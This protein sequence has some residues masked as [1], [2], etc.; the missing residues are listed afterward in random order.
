MPTG[1][2]STMELLHSVQNAAVLTGVQPT[3]LWPCRTEFSSAALASSHLQNPIQVLLPDPLRS[4]STTS[5]SM[6]LP[7]HLTTIR[8]M[9]T[10]VTITP[11]LCTKFS[12]HMSTSCY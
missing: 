5:F 4:T 8:D 10:P 3:S 12:K 2:L 6:C 1:L 7:D 11:R 9:P